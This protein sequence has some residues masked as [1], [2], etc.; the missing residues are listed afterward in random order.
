MNRI[1]CRLVLIVL[2]SLPMF[3]PSTSAEERPFGIEKRIAWTTSNVKGSPEPPPPYGSERAFPE[4]SFSQPIALTRLPESDRL[5]VVE[6]NGRVLSFHDQADTTAEVMIELAKELPQCSRVYGIAFHPR[7]KT[8]R[9]V[10]I[11]YITDG[12]SEF[13]TRVSRFKVTDADPPRITAA[14]EEVI[15]SWQAGGHNGG[16]MKFGPDGYLYITTGDASSPAPPD[17]RNTGQDIS[18]LLASVLR[19]DV[20]TSE[21]DRKYGIPQDNPFVSLKGA[22]PEVWAYG[23]RNPWKISFD[24]KSGSLWLGDV[25]WEMFEMIYRVERGGN[26]GWSI[27]E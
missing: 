1:A 6:L 16:C 27:K 2:L 24:P 12:N 10:F 19:I 26:Y 15:L 21:G 23:F 5:V 11:C 20:D 22:R 25:G 7:F 13:G 4:L 17:V 18:D 14:T 8:S 9:E 3:F